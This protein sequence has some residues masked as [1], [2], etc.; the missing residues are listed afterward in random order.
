MILLFAVLTGILVPALV[1]LVIVL[2]SRSSRYR[3][4]R[5]TPWR[6]ELVDLQTGYRLQKTFYYELEM[7]RSTG[8]EE[9]EGRLFLGN[10]KTISRLQCRLT[11]DVDGV[12]IENASRT[13][14]S[15]LNG[16]KIDQP[17]RLQAGD[18]LKLGGQ[19]FFVSA[20]E[21]R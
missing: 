15:I 18:R 13:N 14:A 10:W 4:E 9:P 17:C 11:A 12:W 21:R 2:R 19:E 6:V 5:D 8:R 7:G 1:I 16:M 3:T 20:L